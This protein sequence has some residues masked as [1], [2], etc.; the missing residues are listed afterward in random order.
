[1]FLLYSLY[2][3]TLPFFNCGFIIGT[4]VALVER[5]TENVSEN[6]CINLKK[7]EIV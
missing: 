1:M 4:M 5:A 3:D 2:I 6:D 7:G